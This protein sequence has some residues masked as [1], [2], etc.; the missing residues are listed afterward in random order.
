MMWTM[1][2]DCLGKITRRNARPD[3]IGAKSR[4]EV[5]YRTPVDD[6]ETRTLWQQWDEGEQTFIVVKMETLGCPGIRGRER[7][8]PVHFWAA[9]AVN[10]L[11]FNKCLV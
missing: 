11:R 5:R 1:C 7:C 3:A 10:V 6:T 4:I 2:V 9:T 8:H